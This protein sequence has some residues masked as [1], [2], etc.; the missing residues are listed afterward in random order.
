MEPIATADSWKSKPFAE[1]VSLPLQASFTTEEFHLIQRGL[2]PQQMEDKWFIYCVDERLHF[3]RSWT[4]MAVYRLEFVQEGAVY[5]VAAAWMAKLE[6]PGL[7][8][9]YEAKLVEF[10]ISTQLLRRPM[11]F[12]LKRGQSGKGGILQHSIVGTG[13]VEMPT[14]PKK[15]WWQ[16]WK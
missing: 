12:P 14:T 7:D 2:I 8:L 5:R 10:L 4:G 13:F 15:K 3:H 6:Q 1:L 16:F 11:P 9:E